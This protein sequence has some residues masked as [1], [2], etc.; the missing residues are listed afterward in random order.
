MTTDL[1]SQAPRTTA[2]IRVIRGVRDAR[3]PLTTATTTETKR[4]T[5]DPVPP[6]ELR[7]ADGGKLVLVDA[8]EGKESALPLSA[9]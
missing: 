3:P 9:D 6:D 2:I 7:A 8:V 5:S 4:L 1:Y